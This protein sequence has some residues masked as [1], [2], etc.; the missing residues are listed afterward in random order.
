[1]RTVGE[2]S[3]GAFKDTDIARLSPAAANIA[4]RRAQAAGRRPQNKGTKEQRPRA[5]YQIALSSYPTQISELL[6]LANDAKSVE[7]YNPTYQ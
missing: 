1:M 4:P 2:H 6:S 5:L 3:Q 7:N